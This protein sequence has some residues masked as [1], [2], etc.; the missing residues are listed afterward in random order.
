ME[1]HIWEELL[2][3]VALLIAVGPRDEQGCCVRGGTS[4]PHEGS[5]SVGSGELSAGAQN[6]PVRYE[7]VKHKRPFGSTEI[8]DPKFQ[9]G[10]A[11]KF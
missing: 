9:D 10:D 7:A 1:I 4:P 8:Q 3:W 11:L 2:W 5:Q 6:S